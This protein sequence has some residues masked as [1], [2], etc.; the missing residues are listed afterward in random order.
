[1]GIIG[2]VFGIIGLA[3]LNVV[4]EGHYVKAGRRV[5]VEVEINATSPNNR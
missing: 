3:V 5:E 4:L 2:C 1:M